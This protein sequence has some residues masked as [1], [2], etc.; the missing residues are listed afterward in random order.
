RALRP[1]LRSLFPYTTLFRSLHAGE[2]WLGLV[3]PRELAFHIG[4]AVE[5]AGARRIGHGVA[6]AFERQMEDLIAEMARRG[7]VVEINLT[8]KDRKSTRLNSSHQI[9]SY[10]V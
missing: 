8:S 1:P 3:P 5:I 4:E 9:I 2:L 10:A 7:V 6:L